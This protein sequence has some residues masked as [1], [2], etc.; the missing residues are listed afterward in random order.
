MKAQAADTAHA[1]PAEREPS[2]AARA[3]VPPAIEDDLALEVMSLAC[4]GFRPKASVPGPCK[5]AGSLSDPT[6]QARRG[7]WRFALDGLF[8]RPLRSSA[9][10]VRPERAA[11]QPFRGVPPICSETSG[12][13]RGPDWS[14]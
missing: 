6:G 1:V 8:L 12:V 11:L 10:G 4:T 14:R 3:Y 2:K 7:V 13:R 9:P 5:T